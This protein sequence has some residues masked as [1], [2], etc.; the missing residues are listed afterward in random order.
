MLFDPPSLKPVQDLLERRYS[1][2]VTLRPQRGAP[3]GT[4]PILEGI[5]VPWRSLSVDLGGFREQF[6]PSAF[7]KWLVADP[8]I[9]ALLNHDVG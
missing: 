3:Q 8:D 1:P 2:G 5:A 6:E 9:V 7:D 4:L